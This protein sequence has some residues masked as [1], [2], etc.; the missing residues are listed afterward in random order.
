MD[1]S[2]SRICREEVFADSCG[3]KLRLVI[4]APEKPEKPK[5][6]VLCSHGYNSCPED[7]ADAAETFAKMGAAVCCVDFRGGS[8]RSK[9]GG[10]SQ[11]MSITSQLCDLCAAAEYVQ[12]G[13]APNKLFLYGESQGGLVSALS[14]EKLGAQAA[15]LLYPAF[16]IPDHWKGRDPDSGEFKLMGMT[17]SGSFVRGLP[18]FDVYEKTGSFG[19]KLLI[20][21]GDSDG[22]VDLSYSRRLA[23]KFG[24]RAKLSVYKGEGHGFSSN[25]RKRWLCEVGEF[26]AENL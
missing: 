10:R 4:F 8:T 5:A 12:N 1:I 24:E 9:S 16:C 2:I 20:G 18:K 15:M 13:F 3:E 7:L 26:L 23:E 14:A 22:L 21:H 25:G 19:G 11:D 6:A 17:L